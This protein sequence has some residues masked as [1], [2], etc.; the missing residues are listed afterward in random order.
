MPV[1]LFEIGLEGPTTEHTGSALLRHIVSKSPKPIVSFFF[2]LV[3]RRG[4]VTGC[5]CFGVRVGVRFE[6]KGGLGNIDPSSSKVKESNALFERSKK[7]C[8]E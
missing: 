8:L 6:R 5:R 2:H 1:G 4:I 7:V 3:V